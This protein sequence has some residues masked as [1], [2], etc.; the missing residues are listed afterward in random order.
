M[1]KINFNKAGIYNKFKKEVGRYNNFSKVISCNQ[2]IDKNK[3]SP[4][5]IN[6][7]TYAKYILNEGGIQEKRDLLLDLKTKFILN[8][9]K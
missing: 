1:D 6:V 3:I 2:K 7:L 5:K 4:N 8:N 9:K